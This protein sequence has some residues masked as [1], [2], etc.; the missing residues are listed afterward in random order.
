MLRFFGADDDRVLIINL[1]NDLTLSPMPEPLLAP[2]E[3]R[4]WD[5]L[6]TSERAKYG[7]MGVPPLYRDGFLH[8]PGESA[9]VLA[10]AALNFDAAPELTT[11]TPP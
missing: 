8:I 9:L 2:P 6:W 5:T 3:D 7:G 11:Q 10:P 1:G 4:A